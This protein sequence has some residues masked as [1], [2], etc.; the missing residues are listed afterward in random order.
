MKAYILFGDKEYLDSF[1][2]AYA[3]ILKY[4]RDPDGF[5]Y[6]RV[7]M[8]SGAPIAH[9]VDSL[10]AFFPGLQVLYGDLHSAM[11]GWEFYYALWKKYHGL[12]ERWDYHRKVVQ[13]ASYPLR[14]E[15]I[16]STY[17][18]YQVVLKRR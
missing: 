5:L 15:L 2:N 1:E 11:K 14:P 6:R 9:W 3:A 4:V 7:N 17:M 10:G 12:P 8:A 16:E 13:I 18:L